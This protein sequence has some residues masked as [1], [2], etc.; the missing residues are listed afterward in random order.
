MVSGLGQVVVVDL[1]DIGEV[2]LALD[3]FEVGVGEQFV[4]CSGLVVIVFYQQLVVGQQMFWC[5]VD[6]VV[7]VGQ[8][9]IVIGEC[10][11]WFEM[12][13][14]LGEVYIFCDDI[15]WVGGDYCKVLILGQGGVLVV[16]QQCYVDLVGC[17]VFVCDGQCGSIGVQCCYYCIGLCMGDGD[18]NCV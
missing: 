4:Y 14:V 13:V 8:V 6:D 11:D 17:G 15:R 3:F 2:V 16:F 18:G 9:I 5:V 1:F 12:Q 7:Q 10:I